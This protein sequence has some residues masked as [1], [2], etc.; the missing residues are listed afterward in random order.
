MELARY[1]LQKL[2]GHTICSEFHILEKVIGIRLRQIASVQ[3]QSKKRTDGPDRDLPVDL[4]NEFL[5]Q[6][7]PY[8]FE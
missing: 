7:A 4:A 3:V 1:V 2:L 6:L 8:P 5:G